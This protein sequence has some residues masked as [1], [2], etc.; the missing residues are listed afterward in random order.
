MYNYNWIKSHI[1]TN[2]I[3]KASF[4]KYITT[5]R[6]SSFEPHIDIIKCSEI[7][8]FCLSSYNTWKLFRRYYKKLYEVHTNIVSMI[9]IEKATH[10]SLNIKQIVSLNILKCFL[11]IQHSKHYIIMF[12]ATNIYNCR[13]WGWSIRIITSIY[14]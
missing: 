3:H 11:K 12:Q 10:S 7:N 4:T 13:K 9:D 14:K 5:N 6:N 8:F 1:W 2:L